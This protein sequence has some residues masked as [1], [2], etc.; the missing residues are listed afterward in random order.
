MKLEL[1]SFPV[2]NV[3]FTK[4]MKYRDYVLEIHKEELLKAV[5]EDR[6]IASAEL[7]LAFPG[8]KTRIVR[9]RGIV[10][11]R[12]KVS[13]PGCVFP[14]V[15][16]PVETVGSGRTHRLSGLAV[17]TSADYRPTVMSGTGAPIA[18]ILDLW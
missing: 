15:L 16:G 17:T 10:E 1:V 6:R 14:G 2:K 13:G 12:V 7:D 4:P 3:L 9:I 11:P 5:L 18:G 8:D